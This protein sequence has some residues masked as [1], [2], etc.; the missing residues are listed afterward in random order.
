MNIPYIPHTVTRRLKAV[1]EGGLSRIRFSLHLLVV[2]LV[3]PVAAFAQGGSPFDN[4]FTALQ[5]LFTGTVAK[6]FVQGLH[7][8]RINQRR[9]HD[10]YG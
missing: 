6:V 3:I 1:H 10:Q 8:C 4:G 9:K 2:L 7:Q 5:T